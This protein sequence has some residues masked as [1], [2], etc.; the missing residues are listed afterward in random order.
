MS[1]ATPHPAYRGLAFVFNSFA[2]GGRHPIPS[3]LFKSQIYLVV[4]SFCVHSTTLLITPPPLV[5]LSMAPQPFCLIE[6]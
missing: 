5:P 2:P 4:A 3:P 1:L 6:M